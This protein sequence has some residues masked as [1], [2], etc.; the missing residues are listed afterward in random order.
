[1]NRFCVYV[2]KRPDGSPFY[3][4]K[5]TIHRAGI[6]L[7]T[8]PHHR[9]IVN[10]FGRDNITVEIVKRDMSEQEALAMEISLIALMR[11]SG[12]QLCNMSSGGDGGGVPSTEARRRMSEAQ[13]RRFSNPSERERN[14]KLISA[15]TI[16]RIHSKET[17]AKIANS[18]RGKK[19]SAEAKLKISIAS[20]G[21][22]CSEETRKKIGQSSKGNRRA[23]GY[24]FTEEQLAR[25]SAA[26]KGKPWSEKRRMAEELRRAQRTSK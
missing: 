17:I 1:M 9:N 24:K 14:G 25:A 22:V 4:G 5:G 11:E 10:K 21:R 23:L 3:I 19:H 18:N 26:H 8:N 6:I 15:A 13:I 12:Q 7:R 16:G 20:A 2:H